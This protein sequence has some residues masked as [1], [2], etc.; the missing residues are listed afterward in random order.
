MPRSFTLFL[1]LL[2]TGP[3]FA[4]SSPA[5]SDTLPIRI[6]GVVVQGNK[7]TQERIILRELVFQEGDTMPASEFYERLERGRQ[8]L[9]NTGLFN[10]VVALPI[11]LDTRSVIVEVTVNERW[12]LWPSVKFR[13]ADPNFN[14]WWLTKDLSRVNYGLY[15]T[16]YNFRGMNETISAM[17]QFGYTKQVALRY[18]APFIDKDQRWG[19]SIGGAYLEQEEVT[20]ATVENLR[21]LIKN[22][23]GP[24]RTQRTADLELT[25]RRNHDF[26]HSWRLRWMSASVA[27]TITEVAMDYFD[28]PAISSE[29]MTLGYGLVWDRRDMRAYPRSGHYAEFRIDRYGLGF[30]EEASPDITTVYGTGK[31]W[32]HLSDRTT[33]AMSLRGKATFGEPPY[34][35]QEGLGYD[36]HVRGYEYYVIDGEHWALGKFNFIFQLV[37]PVV[38][39][40]EA[41]PM[42]AFRTLYF[43]LYLDLFVD[44]GRV[45]DSR[46]EEANFLAD[47]WMSGYGVGLD[48]VSSYDQV[49]RAE[50]TLNA[51]GEHG[52]FLHFTQPF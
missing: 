8:N 2:A 52:F 41:V 34:F 15:L 43:A 23:D 25:L 3:L 29:Y 26:R 45:W 6:L 9:V 49:I 13:L 39:R 40:V 27:D 37:E 28:G 33:L 16:K 32:W 38:R 47:R 4:W 11:F 10:T 31:R 17:V 36:H 44:G 5:P 19:L 18:K 20:A 48:I 50:Y 51:L 22:P 1:V 24:N 35:V 30:A 21:V 14:T 7:V 46:Y 12:Y 42:E